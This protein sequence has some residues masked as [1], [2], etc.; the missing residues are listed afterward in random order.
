MLMVG[1][2]S[3]VMFELNHLFGVQRGITNREDRYHSYEGLVMSIV[4]FKG[5]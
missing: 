1:Q 2:F 3:F 5:A 4:F